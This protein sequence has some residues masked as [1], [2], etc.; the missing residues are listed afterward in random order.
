MLFAVYIQQTDRRTMD[1]FSLTAGVFDILTLVASAVKIVEKFKT[2]LKVN[3]QVCSL[4]NQLRDL[5]CVLAFMDLK[6]ED[7]LHEQISHVRHTFEKIIEKIME[8]E[9]I[10][11]FRLLRRRSLRTEPAVNRIA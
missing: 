9:H 8:L 5:K 4:I 2:D 7:S 1:P 3:S 6:Q 10:L 11:N